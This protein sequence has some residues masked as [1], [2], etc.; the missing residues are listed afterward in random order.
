M[1]AGRDPINHAAGA[2]PAG[3]WYGDGMATLSMRV[4]VA[5]SVIENAGCLLMPEVQR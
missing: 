4:M 5:Q 1:P 3:G 2:T